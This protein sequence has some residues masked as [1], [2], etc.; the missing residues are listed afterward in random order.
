[1]R[2]R[3]VPQGRH[4]N[5]PV[6]HERTRRPAIALAA[7]LLTLVLLGWWSTQAELPDSVSSPDSTFSPDR[8][9]QAATPTGSL[10]AISTRQSSEAA[11][12]APAAGA[13]SPPLH[14]VYEAVGMDQTVLPLSPT[15]QE[16]E[17]G[18]IVPPRTDD[19]FWLN[20]YGMPGGESTN[21]TYIVGHSW[22]GRSSPFNNIS[23]GAK[24]GDQLTI[25]TG[26]GPLNY[27]IDEVT[28][29]DK[30]TLK[31]SPIWV[32]V[33]GKLVLITCYTADIWETN[34]IIQA[35]PRPAG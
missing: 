11:P 19:A 25:T 13:G 26:E 22:E 9:V 33:P 16:T 23:A 3:P 32:K 2:R 17:A 21:T 10:P 24:A 5:T 28:T 1:M 31:D 35:S 7:A 4:C 18:S 6:F 34:I 8:S 15:E 27:I 12:E 29:E 14:I 30:D 20:T